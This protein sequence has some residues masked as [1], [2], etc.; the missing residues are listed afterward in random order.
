V[1]AAAAG[2]LISHQDIVSNSR[3]RLSLIWPPAMDYSSKSEQDTVMGM[4]E[5][6]VRLARLTEATALALRSND[7]NPGVLKSV[8]AKVISII[9]TMAFMTV[10][11]ARSVL[12]LTEEVGP[13][14]RD[15]YSITR[16]VVE[17]CINIAFIMAIGHNAAERADR[18]AM[19]K[20]YRDINRVSS[21]GGS[22]IELRL[23]TTLSKEI[24]AELSAMAAEFATS[25]GHED[26]SW[27]KESTI[28]RLDAIATRFKKETVILLH[29]AL[30]NIYRHSSEVI[31]GTYFAAV[32]FFGMITLGRGAPKSAEQLLH[33]VAEHQITVLVS[34][35]FA[36]G[37][38]LE[39][40]GEYANLSELR[41]SVER[42]LETMRQLPMIKQ[43]W[44]ST[45]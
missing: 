19:Q 7:T 24:E 18:H 34:C 41:K 25:K 23:N 22:K 39:C 38:L 42:E 3:R 8:D 6:L 44:E 35:V 17:S 2:E 16:S 20:G 4:R 1:G 29:T 21:A 12:K 28:Q 33:R 32:H 13:Q 11:S 45:P 26:R 43:G 10:I 36:L 15:C 9:P 14:V 30:V 27:T 37:G 31:H 40:L 5:V